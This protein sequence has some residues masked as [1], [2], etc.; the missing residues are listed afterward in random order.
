MAITFID[1]L[2]EEKR[3]FKT[4]KECNIT[5]RQLLM[6]LD[7]SVPIEVICIEPPE[8]P[9]NIS[10]KTILFNSE[11]RDTYLSHSVN[12]D[13]LLDTNCEYVIERIT[14]SSTYCLLKIEVQWC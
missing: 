5:L 10:N 7:H 13:S 4:L 3:A 8:H 6:C 9:N 2:K 1:N 12:L 14:F 11:E